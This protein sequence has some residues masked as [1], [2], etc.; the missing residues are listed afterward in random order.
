[1]QDIITLI[2]ERRK[3]D[4]D[5]KGFCMGR[6]VPNERTRPIVP[7]LPNR[8]VILEIKRASPSKGDI[9]ATLDAAKTTKSYIKAGAA[10]ISV[11]TEE[12]WFKGSLDDLIAASCAAGEE[13]AVLRK[14]FLYHPDEVDVSY[15][16]GA[17]AVLVI[18]RMLDANAIEKMLQRVA[19]RGMSALVEIRTSDDV[20]KVKTAISALSFASRL[21]NIIYGVNARDLKDFS[22]DPLAPL[23]MQD[24]ISEVLGDAKIITE[25]GVLSPHAAK[26]AGNMGFYGLLLGEAAAKAPD[27]AKGFVDA[28]LSGQKESDV[29]KMLNSIFWKKIAVKRSFAAD[30]VYRPLIKICGFTRVQD[31][32]TAA[33][34]GADLLGF[35]FWPKSKR[36]CTDKIVRETRNMIDSITWQTGK[37]PLLIGVAAD[38]SMEAQTAIALARESVLDAVQFHSCC[39]E[40]IIRGDYDGIGHYA[41]VSLGD[42]QDINSIRAFAAS[43]EMRVLVDAKTHTLPGGTGARVDTVLLREASK[44]CPLWVAGGITADNV[45]RIIKDTHPELID[46]ASGVESNPGIKS[47]KKMESLVARAFKAGG[48]I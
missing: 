44:V 20:N 43:G 38:K 17:D 21:P 47:K 26:M 11:L 7:F 10:A 15:R 18:A 31:A 48:L 6:G 28:F 45:S 27:G 2:L 29:S 46:T 3:L 34:A 5:K 25:S 9:A 42:K 19:E 30:G 36:C 16:C 32:M 37:K 35:V 33:A 22:I 12:H 23:I 14:D 1:M 8:G 39:K 4:I 24:K 13:A 40:E 41:A